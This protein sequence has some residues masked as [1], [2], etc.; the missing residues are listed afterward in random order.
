M[1]TIRYQKPEQMHGIKIFSKIASFLSVFLYL[2]NLTN[3]E[4]VHELTI[5][6]QVS[7]LN[8]ILFFLEFLS[9]RHFNRMLTHEI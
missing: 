3:L 8:L 4:K 7:L 1:Q 9:M 2:N 6:M 5:A